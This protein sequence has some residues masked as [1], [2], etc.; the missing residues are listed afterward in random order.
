MLVWFVQ[1][2]VFLFILF[3]LKCLFKNTPFW[4]FPPSVYIAKWNYEIKARFLPQK[5]IRTSKVVHMFIGMQ[6]LLGT[7]LRP[8]PPH[9]PSKNAILYASRL[10]TTFLRECPPSKASH[11][12]AHSRSLTRIFSGA[13][14][15]VKN[16]NFLHADNEDWSDCA[17]VRA[18]LSLCW[19]Y[20][21]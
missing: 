3:S 5:Y 7:F 17:D 9:L 10:Q 8:P 19:A 14:W 12:P 16:A 18:D 13:F 11:Q 6:R 15:I 4:R 2:D 21:P 20:K 1:S